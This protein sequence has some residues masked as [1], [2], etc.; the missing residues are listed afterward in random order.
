MIARGGALSQRGARNS[1]S[2]LGRLVQVGI[3]GYLRKQQSIAE[4]LLSDGVP[5]WAIF[6]V[7][8]MPGTVDSSRQRPQRKAAT[9]PQDKVSGCENVI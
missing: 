7:F 3:Y 5:C 6:P 9:A 2:D 4:T 1:P 8:S